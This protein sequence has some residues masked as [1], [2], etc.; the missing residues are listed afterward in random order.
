MSA[1]SAGDGILHAENTRSF[2]MI[3]TQVWH[4]GAV[5][6]GGVTA[7]LALRRYATLRSGVIH[8]K[9]VTLAADLGVSTGTVDNWLD[10]LVVAGWLLIT[11]TV[12]DG[13]RGRGPNIY[14][15]LWDPIDSPDDPRL[16]THQARLAEFDAWLAAAMTG[17]GLDAGKVAA[18]ADKR[19]RWDPEAAARRLPPL[20][21]SCEG[22][23]DPLANSCEAP[24]AESC[25]DPSQEFARQSKS[26]L[27][28]SQTF[29]GHAADATAPHAPDET[30]EHPETLPGLPLPADPPTPAPTARGT[31]KRATRLDPDWH[32]TPERRAWAT[33]NMPG[34]DPAFEADQFR[35]HWLAAPGQR[36]V[37]QDWEATWRTWCRNA[38]KYNSERTGAA[39]PAARPD[40]LPGGWSKVVDGGP[41]PKPNPN[42]G[43]RGWHRTVPQSG[44]ED[45]W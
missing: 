23:E 9:R 40:R 25:E 34:I 10:A 29:L 24:L 18:E 2:D 8:L 16:L 42:P 33:A 13:G 32:L 37:K 31:T 5:S 7:Y 15:L 19:V 6:T 20:A 12:R 22:G 17:N 28:H 14:S 3:P 41:P 43:Q 35:D 21:K 30:D 45:G 1:V 11:P 26:S 4:R 36:G 39:V 27:S 44:M 38:A